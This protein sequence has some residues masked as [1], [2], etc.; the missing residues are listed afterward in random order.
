MTAAEELRDALKEFDDHENVPLGFVLG[1]FSSDVLSHVE[2]ALSEWD[3]MTEMFG[4]DLHPEVDE[5]LA[6]LRT[7]L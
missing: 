3:S 7:A 5:F 4:R 1:F 2:S 6:C